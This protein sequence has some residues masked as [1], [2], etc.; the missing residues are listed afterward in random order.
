MNTS[1]RAVLPRASRMAVVRLLM[2]AELQLGTM[3][4]SLEVDSNVMTGGA[5]QL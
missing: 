3:S 2:G 4:I 1:C 5:T